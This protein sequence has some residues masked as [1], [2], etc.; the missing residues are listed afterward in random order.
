MTRYQGSKRRIATSIVEALSDLRYTTVL[1]ACGGTGAVSYAFKQAGKAVTYNDYLAFNH[2]IGTALI[3]NH[4]VR[5]DDSAILEIGQENSATASG[6]VVQKFF[7]GVYFTDDENRWLDAAVQNVR[8]VRN[9]YARAIVWYAI[10]QSA[11]AKRPY[12]LFHRANL[13][14]RQADVKRGFGNKASWD[15]SFDQHMLRFVRDANRAVFDNG[16]TCLATCRDVFAVEPGFDLVYLDPPYMNRQCVGV[17]Y[18]DFYHFLE[19][20]V[21]YDRWPAMIDFSSKHRRMMREENP[22]LDVKN[23][24]NGY[25]RF[26]DRF[27]DGIIA[28]S[29][30]TNGTPEIQELAGALGEFKRRVR[31]VTLE[32]NQY[33]LSS[34][35]D[36]REAL[37]V[38]W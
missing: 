22:F 33:V 31:V 24:L 12:N 18:R 9:R 21:Q 26:F 15:R 34:Q 29:Y 30:R 28:V 16:M 37:I 7:Q 10:F 23:C 38:G 5:L 8:K 27:R 13:Y 25:R 1:D 2:L 17:D 36:T 6:K 35:R 4:S 19:G 14:M 32:Q 3:E 11:L 20:L